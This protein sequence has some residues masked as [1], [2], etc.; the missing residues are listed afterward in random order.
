MSQGVPQNQTTTGVNNLSKLHQ[1]SDKAIL[2]RALAAYKVITTTTDSQDERS[3]PVAIV[4]EPAK[5][6]SCSG[7]TRDDMD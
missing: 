1:P 4:K 2:P 7:W 3:I 6:A 5:F